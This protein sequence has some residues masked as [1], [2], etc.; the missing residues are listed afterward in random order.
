VSEA[1]HSPPYNVDIK[2]GGA[3]PPLPHKF[4]W[5]DTYLIKTGTTSASLNMS[6]L[7]SPSLLTSVF[8]KRV[9]PFVIKIC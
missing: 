4:S 9:I 6:E 8:N 1:D 5:S 7:T 3:I 2:N